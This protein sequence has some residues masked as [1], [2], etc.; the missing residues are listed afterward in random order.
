MKK[1]KGFGLIGVFL[2][3]I[4]VGFMGIYGSQIGLEYINKNILK[5]AME[6]TIEEAKKEELTD[7]EIKA[8]FLKKISMD[9]IEI[10]EKDLEVSQTSNGI[11]INVDYLKEI[12]INKEI[13]IMINYDLSMTK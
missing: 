11:T 13:S 5:T 2:T 10:T 1:Q 8:I 12:E 7:N 6:K 3:I 4:F 9:N